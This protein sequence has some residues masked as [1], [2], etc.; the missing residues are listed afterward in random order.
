MHRDVKPQNVLLDGEGRAKVTDFGI[1]RSLEAVGTTET[2]TVLGLSHYV[3]PEQ[4]RGEKVDADGRLLVRRR[5]L[6]AACR[7]RVPFTG[8][9][10]VAVALRH[11]NE[12]VPDVLGAS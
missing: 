9:S 5:P 12:P 2:G 6:R 11:V 10:F 8:S 3:A 4:A 1:V 7:R